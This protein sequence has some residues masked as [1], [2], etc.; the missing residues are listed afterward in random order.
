MLKMM[1]C[2][3]LSDQE[4]SRRSAGLPTET[5][6]RS[7]DLSWSPAAEALTDEGPTIDQDDRHPLAE[8]SPMPGF[9]LDP[10]EWHSFE[11]IDDSHAPSFRCVLARVKCHKLFC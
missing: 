8:L 7:G 2:G 6:W 4:V 5:T 10:R 9:A 3:S 11:S 1:I